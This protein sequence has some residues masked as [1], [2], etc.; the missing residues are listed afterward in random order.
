VVIFERISSINRE[1]KSQPPLSQESFQP[2]FVSEPTRMV[3]TKNEFSAGPR[4]CP[5]LVD[6]WIIRRI[7]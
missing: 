6:G 1:W 5:K 2:T 3:N 4:D 7:E